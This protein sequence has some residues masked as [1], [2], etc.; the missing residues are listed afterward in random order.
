MVENVFS[1][2]SREKKRHKAI[3][4]HFDIFLMQTRLDMQLFSMSLLTTST[5]S[6]ELH[7]HLPFLTLAVNFSFQLSFTAY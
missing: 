1:S 6:A 2:I 7:S 3:F 4:K 5:F